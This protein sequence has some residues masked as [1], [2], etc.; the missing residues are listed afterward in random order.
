MKAK[1]GRWLLLTL[2]LTVALAG[3][4]AAAEEKLE[5]DTGQVELYQCGSLGGAQ[6]IPG[7]V[8]L[9]F[10]EQAAYKRIYEGLAAK[11]EKIDISEFQ[12]S[13]AEIPALYE[14]VVNDNP[15]LFYVGSYVTWW[16]M[17]STVVGIEPQYLENLPADAGERMEQ[18]VAAALSQVELGMSQTEKALVLHD[19]LMDTVAYDWVTAT[20]GQP[21]DKAVFS[22]YGALV[23]RN[24]VCNGY[25]LAYQMLLKQVG[26][27]SVK[28]DS[29]ALNHAWNLVEIDGN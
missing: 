16:V 5:C 3:A 6:T 29:E 7:E 17:G 26:I 8:D 4:A 20:T 22:A 14:R 19:Y 18:A 27:N 13:R 2:L 25:A 23:N 12:I 24:A 15:E 11:Q 1:R 9:L 28:L 21:E 10:D